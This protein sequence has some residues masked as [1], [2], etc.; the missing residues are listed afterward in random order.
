MKLRDRLILGLAERILKLASDGT[1]ED[2]RAILSQGSQM[3][4]QQRRDANT[5]TAD[6]IYGERASGP[7]D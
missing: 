1:R 6:E 7:Q 4:R 3:V 5:I 2:L